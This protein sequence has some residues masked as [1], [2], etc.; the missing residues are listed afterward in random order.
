MKKSRFCFTTAAVCLMVF[1]L[2]MSA[3][4]KTTYTLER[5]GVL[6]IRMGLQPQTG[7]SVSWGNGTILTRKAMLLQDGTRFRIHGITCM[8]MAPWQQESPH[9]TAFR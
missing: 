3:Q 4:A 1:G 5:E 8:R 7:G 2:S 6:P 9:R